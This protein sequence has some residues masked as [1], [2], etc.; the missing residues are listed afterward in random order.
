[1]AAAAAGKSTLGI[2][3]SVGKEF[4]QADQLRGR[5]PPGLDGGTNQ[6]QRR[7]NQGRGK[8]YG[9]YTDPTGKHHTHW[10]EG[11]SYSTGGQTGGGAI[12]GGAGGGAAGGGS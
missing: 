3:K 2:P 12:G 11:K 8:R 10:K 1:M 7:P 5:K 4:M 6:P 9:N